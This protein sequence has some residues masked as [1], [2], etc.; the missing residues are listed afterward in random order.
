MPYVREWL[1]AARGWRLAAVFT[2]AALLL[3]TNVVMATVERLQS[4]TREVRWLRGRIADKRDLVEQQRQEIAQLAASVDRLT[5]TAT[6]LYERS[7]D[8]RRLAHMEES[9]GPATSG[10]IQAAAL[11][12]GRALVS[13]DTARS[14]DQLAWLD[15]QLASTGDSLAVLTALLK[16]R[17]DRATNSGTAP[18]IW[19]V[20][21]EVTSNFG[22][23]NSPWGE[24]REVHPGVDIRAPYG[25]PVDAAGDGEVVFSGRDP[26][27]GALVIID[28]GRQL[29]TLYGHLSAIYVREGQHVRRGQTIAAI[30]A[31]GRATGAHLHYEVRLADAP[32]NPT[33]YLT[34]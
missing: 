28:H 7:R 33:R 17:D 5:R 25:T 13:D 32:V 22:V 3:G 12:T 15:S 1:R 2:G 31:S 14:L 9:R 18:S 6:S 30:G 21:G 11:E 27:Y 8:A 20:R 16:E 24:G 19:P 4:A 10:G 29:R 23:R 34:D 26:G